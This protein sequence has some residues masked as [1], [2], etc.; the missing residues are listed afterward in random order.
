MFGGYL[1]DCCMIDH[2]TNVLMGSPIHIIN[3]WKQNVNCCVIYVNF[4]NGCVNTKCQLLTADVLMA[5]S[6]MLSTD[7]YKKNLFLYTNV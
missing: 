7:E 6:L 1:T 3:I 4:D 2:M 5:I